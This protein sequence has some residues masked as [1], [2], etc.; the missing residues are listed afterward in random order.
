[1]PVDATAAVRRAVEAAAGP[2]STIASCEPL[3]GDT[4][5]TVLRVTFEDGRE[6]VVKIPPLH[7]A[8]M[9]YERRLLVNEVTFHGTAA[10]VAGGTIPQIVHSELDA[11]AP[12]GPYVVMTACPGRPWHDL[13]AELTDGERRRL[14]TELG[15]LVGRLHT[16]TGPAGFGYP[17]EPF[18]PPAAT[19]REAFTA[20]TGAVLADA[21][22]YGAR[23]PR[24]VGEI[25]ALLDAAAYA[26]DD[27]TR[28]ALVHF[29]LWQGNLLVAGE[30]GARSIG[31][32]IDGERMFWGDPVADFV[33]TALFGDVEEDRDFLAGYAS[34][35]GG[36]VV[37]SPSVRLRLA[38]YRS[39]LYLIM[40]TETV[41]RGVPADALEWTRAEVAPRLVE[42]LEDVATISRRSA[43][44]G[45]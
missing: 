44:S 15:E 26:L 4:Y 19:W 31:G 45:G 35:A 43:G 30:P 37:F 29:D 21:E 28:P 3:T 42:A 23:L 25:R 8:G 24:P 41:P 2:G 7:R 34:T 40:L 14:R 13:A 20:M 18:G 12:T 1:M 22:A 27:V 38:L 17:A 10:A 32:V 5:N 11:G 36:P 16:V 33:S 9:S 39:Y 6:W